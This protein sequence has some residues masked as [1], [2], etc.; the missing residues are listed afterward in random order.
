MEKSVD[1]NLAAGETEL[2][3]VGIMDRGRIAEHTPGAVLDA[4]A[5]DYAMSHDHKALTYEQISVLESELFGLYDSKIQSKVDDMMEQQSTELDDGESL[6]TNSEDESQVTELRELLKK[7]ERRSSSRMNNTEEV[8]DSEFKSLSE[9]HEAICLTGEEREKYFGGAGRENFFNRYHWLSKQVNILQSNKHSKTTALPTYESLRIPGEDDTKTDGDYYS[10]DSLA[11]SDRQVNKR[12]GHSKGGILNRDE[13]YPLTE[14]KSPVNNLSGR[15]SPD[16][17][18]MILDILGSLGSKS[19]QRAQTKPV[20]EHTSTNT[21]SAVTNSSSTVLSEKDSGNKSRG[22]DL[23]KTVRKVVMIDRMRGKK[24]DPF[25]ITIPEPEP[26]PI[27]EKPKRMNSHKNFARLLEHKRKQR[28]GA[29]APEDSMSDDGLSTTDTTDATPN[30]KNLSVSVPPSS[31]VVAGNKASKGTTY[32]NP[33]VNGEK[34]DGSAS[35][36]GNSMSD[37][38]SDITADMRPTTP[39]TVYLEGCIRD[40]VSPKPLIIRNSLKKA[41]RLQGR[42]I[43]DQQAVSVSESVI[44]LPHIEELNVSD[45][46]LTDKGSKLFVAAAMQ[47]ES[48]VELDLSYNIIGMYLWLLHCLFNP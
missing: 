16:K 41:L 27:P 47:L 18:K 33:T 24:K 25:D 26:E 42:G 5:Q 17:S 2:D 31:G 20:S 4:F 28:L 19:K 32:K 34:R 23:R 11:S 36:D 43:G 8:F 3:P 44:S 9:Q 15:V 1:A 45:N 13:I 30:M 12:D 14:V 39:R 10:D 7:Q 38:L 37:M 46:N 22:K 40:K 6:D 29:G 35:S 21:K 48:L